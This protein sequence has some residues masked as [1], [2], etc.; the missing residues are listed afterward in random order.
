MLTEHKREGCVDPA[1]IVKACLLEGECGMA[2][3]GTTAWTQARLKQ[4]V[5]LAKE[6]E[7]KVA[8]FIL[9]I[10]QRVDGIPGDI[11]TWNQGRAALNSYEGR[12]LQAELMIQHE[13]A[14]A[15]RE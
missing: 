3:E 12:A 4:A 14:K 9:A 13:A 1:M 15:S 6:R 7:C 8:H 10:C 2:L 11:R 5:T